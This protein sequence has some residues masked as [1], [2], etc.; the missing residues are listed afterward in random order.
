MAS[1]SAPAL[2][3][4][5]CQMFSYSSSSFTDSGTCLKCSLFLDLE[6]RVSDL[7]KRLCTGSK[8]TYVAVA[9]RQDVASGAGRASASVSLASPP[10][11]NGWVTVHGKHSRKSKTH[12]VPHHPVHVSNRFSPLSDSGNPPTEE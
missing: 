5:M 10:A 6:A 7:E 1:P 9:S 8:P 11:S 3:C 12:S 4:P 2:S